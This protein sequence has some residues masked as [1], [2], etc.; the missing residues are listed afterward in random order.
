MTAEL[1]IAQKKLTLLQI[2]E[3][4]KN[5][6][7]A[8][9]RAGV[10]RSQFYEYKRA[11]QE[12]GF[13]GLPDRSPVPKDCPHKTPP[14]IQQR[15]IALSLEHP[16]WGRFRMT[17]HPRL[18]GISISAST[19]RNIWVKEDM[20]TRY[21]RLLRLEEQRNGTDLTLAEEQIWLLEKAN[22]CFRERSARMDRLLRSESTCGLARRF[23]LDV[24]Q[25]FVYIP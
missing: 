25:G 9:R 21:K 16:A 11:F 8:C 20:E 7:E 19:V 5:V 24:S 15:V 10:S 18:E 14:E 23:A 2:A 4:I 12:F 1:K 17:D 22:P 6:S 13:E 3:K